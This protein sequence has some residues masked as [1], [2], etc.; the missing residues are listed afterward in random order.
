VKVNRSDKA[1]AASMR[2][3]VRAAYPGRLAGSSESLDDARSANGCVIPR[4]ASARKTTIPR[5]RSAAS[6][7]QRLGSDRLFSA[8]VETSSATA[9]DMITSAR[10]G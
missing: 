5:A 9:G 6:R 1:I 8:E 3:V 7:S 2:S 4:L 10:R